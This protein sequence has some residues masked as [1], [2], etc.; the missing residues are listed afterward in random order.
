MS[1][2]LATPAR[3]FTRRRA[4][5]RPSR[6]STRR[7]A[8]ETEPAKNATAS[9]RFSNPARSEPAIPPEVERKFM[10]PRSL[11][12]SRAPRAFL[13]TSAMTRGA[14]LPLAAPGPNMP[15]PPSPRA[16]AIA[17]GFFAAPNT[18]SAAAKAV[19]LMA[20][21]LAWPTTSPN[22]A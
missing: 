6:S 20:R 22:A 21:P 17:Q 15:K 10:A 8:A 9:R 3:G 12:L 4:S 5:P 13:L 11:V 2:L 1:A 14:K 19:S 18:R 7:A 16:T